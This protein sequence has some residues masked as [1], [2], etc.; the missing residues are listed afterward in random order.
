MVVDRGDQEDPAPPV[1]EA[2]RLDDHGERL[3]DVDPGDQDE[4]RLGAGDDREAGERAAERHRARVAHEELGREGVVPE[5]PDRGPD[6]RGRQDRQIELEVGALADVARADVADHGD[7]EEGEERDDSG[8]RREAVEAVRQVPTVRGARDDEEE[9]GVVGVR[10]RDVDVGDGDVDR[11][12]ELFLRVDGEPDDDRDPGEQKQFPS[13]LEAERATVAKLDEVVQEPD[14]AASDG[15]EQDGQRGERELRQRQEGQC[16]AEQDQQ[17]AHHRRALLDDMTDGAFLA[18]LRA[19][20]VAAQELDELRPDHD[21][22]DHGDQP[23][24]ED[25]DHYAVRF[26]RAG[27]MPSR[28]TERE[29]LTSTA[30]PGTISARAASRAASAS[31]AHASTP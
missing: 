24:Y 25:S 14:R 16:R 3:D 28:A 31:G 13:A 4:Q 7:R 29:A 9:E 5:E 2:D 26:A 12:V 20:L 23:R 17:A 8:S 18:D 22:D 11:G 6:Q 19:Q 10:E 21:G 1:L 27:A 30:S 15:H